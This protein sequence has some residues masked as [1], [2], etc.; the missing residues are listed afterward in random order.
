M[1]KKSSGNPVGPAGKGEE[2]IP[3]KKGTR[4]PE[5]PPHIMIKKTEGKQPTEIR[6]SGSLHRERGRLESYVARSRTSKRLNHDQT[7]GEK[8]ADELKTW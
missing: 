5:N 2:V 6:V 4:N 3:E 1:I 7:Q 8:R